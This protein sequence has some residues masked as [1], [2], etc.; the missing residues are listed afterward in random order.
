M[1]GLA[2]SRVGRV[3]MEHAVALTEQ[4]LRLCEQSGNRRWVGLALDN[5]GGVAAYRGELDRADTL[6]EQSLSIGKDLGDEDLLWRSLL[7]LGVV[8]MFR[9]NYDRARDLV[10]GAVAN[11]KQVGY[12][13]GMDLHTLGEIESALGNI[14]KAV[15]YYEETLTTGRRLGLKRAVVGGLE[16][17]GKV[18]FD[19]GDYARARAFYEEGLQVAERAGSKVRVRHF[20]CYQSRRIS[21][22]G[23]EIRGGSQTLHW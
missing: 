22:G 9:G 6:L 10:E 5:L 4:G 21:S 12:E 18:A 14:E 2:G 23:G 13:Y 15:V 11:V 20:A 1:S 8:A 16:G 17:L 3:N 7:D 19:Q